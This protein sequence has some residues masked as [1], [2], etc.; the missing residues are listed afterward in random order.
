[1]QTRLLNRFRSRLVTVESNLVR[2]GSGSFLAEKL[3]EG[4]I[5]ILLLFLVALTRL[6]W[7]SGGTLAGGDLLVPINAP[8]YVVDRLFT[9]NTI[10]LGMPSGL[11]ARL[12]NPF[13]GAVAISQY[14]TGTAVY[15]EALY[16]ILFTFLSGMS[17]WWLVGIFS[18][19]SLSAR[20]LF[21]GSL[22]Y[23]SSPFLIND[24]LHTS[25]LFLHA[26]ALI[27]LIVY[28]VAR[29]LKE[30]RESFAIIAAL[31]T[32]I[33]SS[34]MPN[35]K[36]MAFLG[37]VLSLF[38]AYAAL[39]WPSVR[40]QWPRVGRFLCY[41]VLLNL[42]WIAPIALSLGDWISSLQSI[43]TVGTLQLSPGLDK[44]F[45]GVGTWGFNDGYQGL[46][47][48]P[49]SAV[50]GSPAFLFLGYSF[51][52][53]AFA[54]LAIARPNRS[55]I[56]MGAFSLF[57][58]FLTK[59]TQDPFGELYPL[60][61]SFGP[62]KAFRESFY[63]MQFIAIGYSFLIVALVEELILRRRVSVETRGQLTGFKRPIRKFIGYSSRA[64][65]IVLVFLILANS[66]PLLTGAVAENWYVPGS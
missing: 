45:R 40:R 42:A 36:D 63:F 28:L 41:S 13:V 8:S 11:V 59:G 34:T 31:M 6:I 47:Y 58:I 29:A 33:L 15:G 21:V 7:F 53:V 61:V 23:E 20:A 25:V 46:L 48:H 38:L 37:V 32:V 10:D 17:I 14:L 12:F 9:W 27:P 56:F 22:F 49:Y 26:Y 51:T 60:I 66:W 64:L 16:V 57:F 19:L 50:Y 35:F 1:M 24:G 39:S 2:E 44:V 65:P 62:F 30:R 55:T 18:D 54:T 52:I 3:R 5:F 43:Q 4:R